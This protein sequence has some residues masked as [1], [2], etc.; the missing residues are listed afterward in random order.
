[1]PIDEIEAIIEQKLAL[2]PTEDQAEAIQAFTNYLFSRDENGVFLLT[3]YAG[4]G[5][6]TLV[7]AI[8]KTLRELQQHVVLLA[9]TGR[10][11]KVFSL[12]ADETVYTIHRRIYRETAGVRFENSL[13]GLSQIA[14]NASTF[15]LNPSQMNKQTIFIVDEASMIA[16]EGLS[17][18]MFGTGRLLD[19][20]IQYVYGG[21]NCRLM[22]VGDSAQL[23]PVGEELS[24]A[25]SER[26]LA[27]YGLTVTH[28]HLRQVVRQLDQSGILWNATQ[29]RNLIHEEEFY[30]FPTLRLQPFADI[31]VVMGNELIERL[32][33]SYYHAGQDETIVVT[34][35]NKRA[36]IFNLG[37][38]GR[39]LGYE[40][41]LDSG[42]Q[43]IVAKNN[44]FWLKPEPEGLTANTP[45]LS[46]HGNIQGAKSPAKRQ[47]GQAF[48]ANGDMAIVR[49]LRNERSLYGFNFADATLQFPDYDNQEVDCTIL[50]DT[51]RAEAPALTREQQDQLFNAVWEDYPDITNRRDRMKRLRE[52]IYYNA[53]QVKYAYAVTC[54]KAQGGQWQHV[55]IDQGYITEDM[56]TPDYFRWLYTA[57]TRATEKVYLINWPK[58]QLEQES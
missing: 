33:D 8:V 41:E 14:C 21:E 10:A 4:T 57:L 13:D 3:G 30:A 16:N 9:P 17:G 51:L 35:S 12:H 46:T 42:D 48:I 25:L 1:M 19:D 27:S 20:L 45:I 36:N 52:D 49:R 55:Y 40:E 56:L 38:R 50:L 6:T 11:A 28:I 26:A 43:V 34:R 47:A 53:L 29:L 58:E 7:G 22:L 37:I 31:E 18:G 32:E 23:P 5:K 54:H 39:I 24:P 2:K 44:Y 15:S